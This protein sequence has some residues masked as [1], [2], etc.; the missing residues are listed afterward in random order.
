MFKNRTDK[1]WSGKHNLTP[2]SCDKII[3]HFV[4]S[5]AHCLNQQDTFHT[6]IVFLSYLLISF[7]LYFLFIPMCENIH[8]G[9]SSYPCVH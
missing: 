6:V 7:T 9:K 4:Y 1:F 5:S 3:S 8:F 2:C